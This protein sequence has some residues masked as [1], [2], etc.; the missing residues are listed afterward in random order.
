MDGH[1]EHTHTTPTPSF[2]TLPTQGG[3]LSARA[4]MQKASHSGRRLVG[5]GVTADDSGEATGSLKGMPKAYD[6][7]SWCGCPSVPLI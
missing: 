5:G 1:E 6:A 7:G 4:C 2:I 3:F